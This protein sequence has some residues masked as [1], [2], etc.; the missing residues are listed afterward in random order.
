MKAPHWLRCRW[1][2]WEPYVAH[3][4][5]TTQMLT[6]VIVALA[7]PVNY[8]QDR[9]CRRCEVCGRSQDREISP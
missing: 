2:K 6:G 4:T 5:Q 8:T 7:E 3:Y 9:E 1:S